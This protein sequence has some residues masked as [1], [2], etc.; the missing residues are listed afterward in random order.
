MAK[1]S[2]K[3]RDRKRRNLVAKYAAKRAALK[4][5]GNYMALDKLPKNASPVRLRNRCNITGRARGYIRKFG[6]SR[7]VFRKWALEGKLP[8]IQK[9]SW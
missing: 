4:E 7:L 8:G 6:V 3:A 5:Q 9:A 2:V 1:E